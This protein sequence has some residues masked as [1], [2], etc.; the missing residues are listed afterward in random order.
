MNLLICGS[1]TWSDYDLLR[2]V[3]KGVSENVEIDALVAGGAVG[4]DQMAAAA[5]K[6]LKIIFREYRADWDKHGKAAGPIRNQE[7]L[8][9]E[10][11]SLLIAFW[12]GKSKGTIDMISRANK[13][14]CRIRIVRERSTP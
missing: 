14:G 9:K 10:H 7:M 4:A 11:P 2:D 12:D 13:A 3:I 1:R 6:E 8:D 5:A